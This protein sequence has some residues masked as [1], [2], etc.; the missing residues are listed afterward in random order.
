MTRFLLDLGT[1][2]NLGI[3]RKVHARLCLDEAFSLS[4]LRL[5]RLGHPGLVGSAVPLLRLMSVDGGTEPSK[6]HPRSVSVCDGLEED[7]IRGDLVPVDLSRMVSGSVGG[8]PQ[9]R[10]LHL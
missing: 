4:R 9:L 3:R 7:G 5:F 6:T 10:D 8:Y 2:A 1:R